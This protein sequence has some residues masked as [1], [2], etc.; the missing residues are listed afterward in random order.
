M[1]KNPRQ[2]YY[3]ENIRPDFCLQYVISGEGEYFINNKT[4][5]L[6]PG[7]LFLLPKNKTHYYKADPQNPYSYYWIHFQ[8]SGMENFLNLI[9]LSE[10]NP[11][12]NIG[13][14][15]T[16]KSV[17][18]DIIKASKNLSSTYNLILIGLGYRLLFEIA[19]TIIQNS[20]V[21]I[22]DERIENIVNYI[23][24]NFQRKISLNELAEISHLSREYM[25]SLFK[26]KLG[27]SPHQYILNY[28]IS[29][30]CNLFQRGYTVSQVYRECGFSEL[31][32]FSVRFKQV[33]GMS[34]LEYKKQFNKKKN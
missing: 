22:F 16:I 30:A 14:N 1:E 13:E 20:N 18:K 5:Q 9:S 32:N 4:Y 33:V 25:I 17:F 15:K 23:T 2:Y 3:N 31:T 6:K 24:E 7:D 29:Y 28:R 21:E 10:A 12:I 8:G 26:K 19:T 34:P 27:V 11:V